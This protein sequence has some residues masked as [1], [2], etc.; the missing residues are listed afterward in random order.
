MTDETGA[1]SA[2]PN[3][4]EPKTDRFAKA[5]AAKA[6]KKKTAPTV[7]SR[8]ELIEL[9]R[10]QIENLQT[11]VLA[12]GASRVERQEATLA[13]I[14]AANEALPPGTYIQIGVDAAGAPIMGKV[15]WT[16]ELIA[17][18]YAPV[19]FTPMRS[20][21]IGPHGVHYAVAAGVEVTVPRIVKDLYD[22][23]IKGE[24]DQRARLRPIDP[25]EAYAI[26][27]R[28]ADAPGTKQWS[29]LYRAGYG[30]E[31][32][33]NEAENTPEGTPQGTPAA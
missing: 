33:G 30:L 17:Q 15:R 29:R 16:R 13:P 11:A 10:K 28:A 1:T 4:E 8:D 12:Q 25:T 5:R 24:A 32:R 3:P 20:M 26:A 2:G 31:I 18:R 27:A 9:M 14:P 6:A 23:V 21:D 22:E 19:T 7:D